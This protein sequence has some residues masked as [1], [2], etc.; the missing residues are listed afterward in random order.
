[1]VSFSEK[2]VNFRANCTRHVVFGGHMW[3]FINLSFQPQSEPGQPEPE[4]PEETLAEEEP[5]AEEAEPFEESAP[6]EEPAPAVEEP[7]PAVEEPVPVEEPP[8]EAEPAYE[9]PAEVIQEPEQ[10]VESNEPEEQAEPDQVAEPQ[11]ESEMV[12]AEKQDMEQQ[13]DVG[14][15]APVDET[16]QEKV[17]AEP[18][19][20]GMEVDESAVKTEPGTDAKEEVKMCLNLVRLS[21][22]HIFCTNLDGALFSCIY[23]S[24]L[25]SR[26]MLN[27]F[28][29][30]CWPSFTTGHQNG[31]MCT[32]CEHPC[33][34]ID[35]KCF[36]GCHQ[37]TG[38]RERFSML[39]WKIL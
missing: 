23:N 37:A 9:E 2:T 32:S 24:L 33:Y 11:E 12:P 5:P 13:D 19:A 16:A 3:F 7:V 30:V 38:N 29:I 28:S 36:R 15:V 8:V 35:K 39:F 25:H 34:M 27:H 4:A 14:E 1:M 26:L 31:E 17:E 18:A 22:L 6:E 10:A 21:C 20:E